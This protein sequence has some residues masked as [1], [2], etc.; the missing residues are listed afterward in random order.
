VADDSFETAFAAYA[1]SA[2]LVAAGVDLTALRDF[3]I[4]QTIPKARV[5]P[6]LNDLR[7]DLAAIEHERWGHWQR[8]MHA[9]C[10]SD[11]Q[12]AEALVIPAKLVAQWERQADTPFADLTA[13][14]QDSDRE[15]V[16]RYLPLLIDRLSA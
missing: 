3:I 13:K 12:E 1:A 15:Q 6:L 2:G 5:A 4:L 8:Y 7:D 16:N 11:A 14:E 9:Q 10:R